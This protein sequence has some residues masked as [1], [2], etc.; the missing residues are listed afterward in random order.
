MKNLKLLLSLLLLPIVLFSQTPKEISSTI[1]RVTVFRK[2]AQVTR[3]AKVAIQAGK[4]QLKFTGISPQIDKRSVQLTADGNFTI[5]SVVHQ[6]NF[7]EVPIKTAEVEGLQK[8]LED[9][10]VQQQREKALLSVYKEEEALLLANKSIG[11]Q[12][13]GVSISDLQSAAELFRQRLQ[14]IKFK[15]LE[16]NQQ[17]AKLTKEQNKIK[18]QLQELNAVEG[19]YTSE[20]L[21]NITAPSAL[22]ADFTLSYIVQNA[23]WVPHYD[24]RVKDIQNP[25]ALSYKANVYQT[26]TEDWSNVLLTLSTS[27]PRQ[28]GT[29][30]ELPA[31]KL[32]YYTPGFAYNDRHRYQSGVYPGQLGSNIRKV[33]GLVTDEYG[34]PLIGAN[35]LLDGT[36][37]G[38]TTDF[39]GKFSLDIPYQ[40][41]NNLLV[42]YLGFQSLETPVTSN[43][44]NIVLSDD[45]IVLEEVVVSGL[46]SGISRK[47]KKK[48][49]KKKKVTASIPVP[50]TQVEKATTVEFTIDIPYTIF[51]DGK[52][53]TVNIKTHEIPAYYEYY[54]APKIDSYAYLTAQVTD[55]EDYKL[56]NGEANLFFEGTYIGKSF[57]DVEE[58]EDTLYLSLGRDNN[59][60]INRNKQKEFS[61]RQ[62][63]GNKKTERR[64]WE[65]ELRN[66][67]AQRI[68]IEVVDQIPLSTTEEIE[69]EH[70]IKNGGQL[71]KET[72]LIKW[73]L[74]LAAG[75][76]AK[77]QFNYK[78]KYPKKK[79]LQLE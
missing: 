46:T 10:Q 70:E 68:N 61:T 4:S 20:I 72:G 66:K 6:L 36:T 54:T 44:M 8:Q 21:V 23:G 62:F 16:I 60:V 55:W 73:K 67:K 58:V 38:T 43:V 59:I 15:K 74:Q 17:L 25:V 26:T 76:N 47:A 42:S 18:A 3:E 78:V 50:T 22:T 32:Q 49:D 63:I 30:P 48:K 56:L 11:G 1:K 41:K 71:D 34:E 77:V 75:K 24:L 33:Q 31:W 57:L 37:I 2:G 40:S 13:S 28:N 53:Y 27:D 51:T 69:V 65:I 79:Q 45:G 5:L 35:V 52:Q 14:E 9:V 29:R 7:L 39:D 64:A 12:Q 19:Q